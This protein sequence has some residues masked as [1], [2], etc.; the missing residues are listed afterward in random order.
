MTWLPRE[1]ATLLDIVSEEVFSFKKSLIEL[2]GFLLP[3]V[4]KNSILI[5]SSSMYSF[6]KSLGLPDELTLLIVAE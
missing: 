5:L 1:K 2:I 4:P 3:L 6:N